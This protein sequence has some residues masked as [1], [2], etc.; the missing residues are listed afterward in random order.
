M[1]P[2]NI[3]LMSDPESPDV[4]RDFVSENIRTQ[5]ETKLAVSR[6]KLH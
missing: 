1:K 4:S 6:G 5:G 3:H 2:D